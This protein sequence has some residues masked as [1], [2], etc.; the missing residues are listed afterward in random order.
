MFI[1]SMFLICFASGLVPFGFIWF[2]V[3][4]RVLVGVGGR[5]IF[6]CLMIDSSKT[7]QTQL[8][9]LIHYIYVGLCNNDNVDG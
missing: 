9:F 7:S 6:V 3:R 8:L 2:G 5:I 1:I 4:V